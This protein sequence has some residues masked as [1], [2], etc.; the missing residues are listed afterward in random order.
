MEYARFELP[1]P[2]LPMQTSASEPQPDRDGGCPRFFNC[3][4]R[5]WR[6]LRH[7]EIAILNGYFRLKSKWIY[8]VFPPP[9]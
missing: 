1:D 8:F 5:E 2:E 6:V 3:L 9:R 4:R 7:G